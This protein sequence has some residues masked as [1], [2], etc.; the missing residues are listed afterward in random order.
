MVRWVTDGGL[1]IN[2]VERSF[3]LNLQEPGLNPS[4]FAITWRKSIVGQWWT[5]ITLMIAKNGHQQWFEVNASSLVRKRRSTPPHLHSASQ[6]RPL[7]GRPDKG[8]S[9]CTYPGCLPSS[10]RAVVS[11]G[12]AWI[13]AACESGLWCHWRCHWAYHLWSF[14]RLS[15]TGTLR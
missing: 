8:L 4:V 2:L 3:K 9:D 13:P 12:L 15:V 1:E 11:I 6:C 10:P 5:A 14:Q 7:G